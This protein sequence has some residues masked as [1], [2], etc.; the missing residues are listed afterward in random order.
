M[1]S[2]ASCCAN[3]GFKLLF[4]N[5]KPNNSQGFTLIE[6]CLAMILLSIIL[7]PILLQ[8]EQWSRGQKRSLTASK[9]YTSLSKALSDYGIA[10]SRYPCPADPA[11]LPGSP[12]HGEEDTARCSVA[13][14][15]VYAGAVPFK[16]LNIPYELTIDAWQNQ[17]FY[18]VSPNLVTGTMTSGSQ[19]GTLR[20]NSYNSDGV[21]T[22]SN[23]Q[24]QAVIF[25]HG[26]NGRGG[27]TINGTPAAAACPTTGVLP[28]E[29]ENCDGD[30]VFNALDRITWEF[31]A[32]GALYYDDIFNY[33]R[34]LNAEVWAASPVS[35][36]TDIFS[37]KE[38]IGI[39]TTNPT[40]TIDVVGNIRADRLS[41]D[42]VCDHSSGDC[43][44][45]EM[46]GGDVPRMNCG[47][48]VMARIGR[49]S[50][51]VAGAECDVRF[52]RTDRCSTGYVLGFQ[53]DGT[54]ICGYP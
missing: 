44:S 19:P 39:G 35:N 43:F 12:G 5:R 11:L 25:S 1:R 47:S 46:I 24:V 9:V 49:L 29:A 16:A 28:L 30:H 21:L 38:F 53:A 31:M 14:A 54:L 52:P 51:G 23:T 45:P 42:T 41:S 48:S 32:E 37:R 36:S 8:Y 33:R 7:V 40:S 13:G 22:S 17:I 34:N 50:P 4:S 27:I 6:L 3:L 2:P 10:N 18:A 26:K 20:V 15:Q